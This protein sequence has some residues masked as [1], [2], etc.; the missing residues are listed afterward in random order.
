MPTTSDHCD[1]FDEEVSVL[2]FKSV[3]EAVLQATKLMNL[4]RRCKPGQAKCSLIS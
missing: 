1:Y 3:E 4:F 2:L